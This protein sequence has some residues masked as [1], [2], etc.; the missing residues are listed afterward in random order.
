MASAVIA[1]FDDLIGLNLAD[2]VFSYVP[3][4]MDIILRRI[5]K[6]ADVPLSVVESCFGSNPRELLRCPDLVYLEERFCLGD[7]RCQ[8]DLYIPRS[9]VQGRIIWSNS[10]TIFLAGATGDFLVSGSSTH[11]RVDHTG[12]HEFWL[13]IDL[14][15]SLVKRSSWRVAGGN[16]IAYQDLPRHYW[17]SA[18]F[19]DTSF[20]SIECHSPHCPAFWLRLEMV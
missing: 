15:S 18:Y 13:S 16:V 6:E 8:P 7:L 17:I 11:I 5:A 10:P 14:P 19:T 3:E 1:L 12:Y 2:E 9:S 20:T 4:A